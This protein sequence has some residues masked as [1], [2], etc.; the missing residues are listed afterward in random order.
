MTITPVSAFQW[1]SPRVYCTVNTSLQRPRSWNWI[2][3]G[4]SQPSRH[5]NRFL[6][7][8]KFIAGVGN[9]FVLACRCVTASRQRDFDYN[10][11]IKRHS[12]EAS[13]CCETCHLPYRRLQQ[14]GYIDLS[15]EDDTK[16]K[17]NTFPFHQISV[18]N[19]C[20][21]Y[22]VGVPRVYGPASLAKNPYCNVY[23]PVTEW[24]KL[25]VSPLACFFFSKAHYI[26]LLASCRHGVLGCDTVYS[27]DYQF[28]KWIYRLN[29]LGFSSRRILCGINL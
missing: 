5:Y 28:L 3:I 11:G 17:R 25:N 22:T 16:Y 29:L 4:F 26:I 19:R 20:L 1:T 24:Y 15:W 12:T 18:Q 13:L 21:L 23:T 2:V 7:H 9:V 14:A 8:A 27:C 10:F 6:L